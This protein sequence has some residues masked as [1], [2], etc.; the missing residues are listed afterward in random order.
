MP[1]A[2][3]VAGFHRWHLAL[4]SLC[5]L[6]GDFTKATSYDPKPGI[7]VFLPSQHLVPYR[8][9]YVVVRAVLCA[10]ECDSHNHNRYYHITL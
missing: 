7:M 9:I 2:L 3:F 6:T 8:N 4:D 10:V 1:A 5:V